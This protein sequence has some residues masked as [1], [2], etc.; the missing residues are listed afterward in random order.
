MSIYASDE[1]SY[2]AP[3]KSLIYFGDRIQPED[4]V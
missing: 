1:C 4:I 2:V 3:D